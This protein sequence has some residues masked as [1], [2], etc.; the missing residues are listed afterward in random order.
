[1]P[2]RTSPKSLF[3]GSV[4]QVLRARALCVAGR[5]RR[6]DLSTAGRYAAQ[7]CQS[8]TRLLSRGIANALCARSVTTWPNAVS[9]RKIR[10]SFWKNRWAAIWPAPSR[11]IWKSASFQGIADL[12]YR[13]LPGQGSRAESAGTALSATCCLNRCGVANGFPMCRSR[14]PRKSASATAWVTTKPPVHCAT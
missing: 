7:G 10:V 6:N 13:S 12:P 14:S 3:A 8:D 4:G 1:M 2:N 5:N 9:P 11:S